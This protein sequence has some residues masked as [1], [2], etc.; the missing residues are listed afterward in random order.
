MITQEA[1]E[2]DAL[3]NEALQQQQRDEPNNI[4]YDGVIH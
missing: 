2:L 3:K 1:A 4:C